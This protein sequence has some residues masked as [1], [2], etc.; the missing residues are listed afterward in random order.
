MTIEHA[1]LWAPFFLCWGSFLNV[2][3]YRLIIGKSLIFPRSA[4]PRCDALIA[5][6]DNIPLLSW[7]LLRGSCR[8]CHQSIS[9]LYPLIEYISLVFF[10]LLAVSNASAYFLSY[11]LFFSALIVTIRSDLETMLISRAVTVYLIPFALILSFFEFLPLTF[12]ESLAG[13][14]IGYAVLYIPARLYVYLTGTDGMGQGDL[15]LLAF[16]G[17]FIGPTGCWITLMIASCMGACIGM[18]YLLIF[19]KD[20]STVIPFGPFLAIAA[21]LTVLWGDAIFFFLLS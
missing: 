6:Y 5:W 3:G 2:A 18:I 12:G 7:I 15:D 1:L 14:V 19:K 8:S 16:I 21:M 20:R 11:A 9:P 10:M 17:S 13:A 4:C